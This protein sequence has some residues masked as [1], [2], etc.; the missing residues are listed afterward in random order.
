M[1]MVMMMEGDDDR[2]D[3]D[4]DGDD[5]DDGDGDWESHFLGRLIR[6]LGVPKGRGVWNSQGER[7][8]K[9]FLSFYVP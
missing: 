8:D 2:V 7:K 9:L 6:S 3:G 5:Q 4:D 1:I